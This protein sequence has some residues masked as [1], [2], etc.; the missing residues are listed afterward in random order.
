MLVRHSTVG[1]PVEQ[2]TAYHSGYL[3]G[4]VL[5]Y[6]GFY[7]GIPAL[8]HY[9]SKHLTRRREDGVVVRWPWWV[10]LAFTA[11]LLVG[12]CAEKGAKYNTSAAVQER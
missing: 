7:I 10:A 4:T 6:A 11:L 1:A 12:Q 2:S 3:I 8:G 5:A 9:A